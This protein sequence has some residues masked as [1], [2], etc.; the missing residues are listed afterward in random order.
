MSIFPQ[1]LDFTKNNDMS[2]I[3]FTRIKAHV[4]KYHLM[5]TFASRGCPL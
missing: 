1:S 5:E 2:E 4:Q 3:D